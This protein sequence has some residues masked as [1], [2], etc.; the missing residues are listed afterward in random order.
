MQRL[1]HTLP[2]SL[3]AFMPSQLMLVCNCTV[4]G[5]NR[6]FYMRPETIF[7]EDPR[8]QNAFR[9]DF[10]KQIST[11]PQ[12]EPFTMMADDVHKAMLEEVRD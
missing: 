12:P 4:K 7:L 6:V 5:D 11:P 3:P 9:N 10:L 1:G 2:L 8:I